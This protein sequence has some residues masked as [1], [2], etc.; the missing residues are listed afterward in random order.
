MDVLTRDNHLVRIESDWEA[1][2]SNGV[3]CQVGRFNP[4]EDGRERILTPLVRKNGSLKAATW[5]EALKSITETIKPL[6]GKEKGVWQRSSRP[7]CRLKPFTNSRASLPMALKAAWSPPSKMA[8]PP[9]AYPRLAHELKKPFEG[10]LDDLR[11]SDCV[12]VVGADLYNKH[13]VAGFFIKRNRPSGT[14]LIVIDAEK[15]DLGTVSQMSSSNP[16]RSGSTRIQ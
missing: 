10:K 9:V 2:V 12:L 16:A 6:A 8:S 3:I 15:N 11:V 7:A 13:Q 5:D 1:P 4:L 14:K